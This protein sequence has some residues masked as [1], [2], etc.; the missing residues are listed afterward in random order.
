LKRTIATSRSDDDQNESNPATSLKGSTINQNRRSRQALPL[1]KLPDGNRTRLTNSFRKEGLLSNPGRLA[2]PRRGDMAIAI[3]SSVLKGR[4]G[5]RGW[6][7]D[8]L[9]PRVDPKAKLLRA[10]RKTVEF[11]SGAG[12]YSNRRPNRRNPRPDMV[13]PSSVQPIPRVTVIVDTSGSMDQRDL[14]LSLDLIG[15]VLNGFRIR[16]GL[17]VICGD[18][19]IGSVGQVFSPKQVELAGGGG[20]DMRPLIAEAAQAKPQP[21][22]IVVCTDG[23]TPWPSEPVGVPVVACITHE[24]AMHAVPFWMDAVCLQ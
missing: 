5:M 14:G 6:A 17:R 15:N 4:G 23:Y 19:S 13:L 12:D 22:V 20:T 18:E 3:L 9:N 11:A 1:R 16:D 24:S 8:V 7:N 2:L 21:G 10:V